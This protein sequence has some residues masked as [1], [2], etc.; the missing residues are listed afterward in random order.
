MFNKPLQ[1]YTLHTKNAKVYRITTTKA[2]SVHMATVTN[3]HLKS[4]I[5]MLFISEKKRIIN[6]TTKQFAHSIEQQKS[7]WLKLE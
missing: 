7:H 2:I 4:K 5:Q 1:D 6:T 3:T